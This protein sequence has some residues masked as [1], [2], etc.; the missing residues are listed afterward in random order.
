MAQLI[1]EQVTS[2][3]TTK[4]DGTPNTYTSKNGETGLIINVMVLK[5][6]KDTDVKPIYAKAFLPPFIKVGDIVT[7]YG[8]I[9]PSQSGNFVNYNFKF[10]TI[11][12]AYIANGD[13]GQAQK[14]AKQDLFNGSEPM[15]VE[16]EDLPF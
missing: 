1:T 3:N 7:I 4:K 2:R 16:D 6:I 9:D 15:E 14:Q 5:G 13:N 11:T 12:K 10:P 8:D